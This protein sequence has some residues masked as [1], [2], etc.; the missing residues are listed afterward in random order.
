M[1]RLTALITALALAVTLSAQNLSREEYLGRYQRLVAR[2]GNAG[3]GVETLIGQ[4]GEAWPDDVQMLLAR[5]SYYYTKCQSARVIQLGQD[6]YLGREPL[7]PMKDSTGATK[8]FFED[9]VFDDALYARAEEAVSRA[10]NLAPLHLDY[11]LVKVTAL[12]AYE[13][14]SP[15]MALAELKSLADQHFRE[16]PAWVYEGVEKIGDEEFK[17]LMEHQEKITLDMLL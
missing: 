1:K 5:F 9:T 17:A 14:G 12:T 2:V 8:N 7:L 4:W 15:D 6:R 16:H 10:I 3:V 13:K 11:R